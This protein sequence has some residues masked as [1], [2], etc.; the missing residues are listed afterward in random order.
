MRRLP[1]P[2]GSLRTGAADPGRYSRSDCWVN[3]PGDGGFR[4]P[5]DGSHG[6]T[7]RYPDELLERAIRFA[8]DL[9]DGPEKLSVNAACIPGGVLLSRYE[10]RR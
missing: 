5:K 2:D 10:T 6:G 1:T 3:R 7:E 8:L 9:V 4:P